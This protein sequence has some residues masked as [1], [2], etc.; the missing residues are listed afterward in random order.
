MQDLSEFSDYVHERDQREFSLGD[1]L[2]VKTGLLLAAFTFLAIQSGDLIKPGLPISQF[3][4]Q[5]LAVL[6]EIIGAAFCAIELWPRDY[7][8]EAMPE[9]Y[10]E[11]IARNEAYGA[12]YPG[13]PLIDLSSARLSAAKQRVKINNARNQFKSTMMFR[14]F[15]CLVI[16]FA[17]NLVTLTMHLF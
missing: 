13:A 17:L 3:A 6:S 7:E 5:A 12:E 8:T 11:W 2:D 15:Y 4:A 1:T 9:R 10:E 14:A 16:G